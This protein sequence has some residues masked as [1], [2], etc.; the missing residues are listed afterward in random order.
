NA[1]QATRKGKLQRALNTLYGSVLS[2]ISLTVPAV[3]LI[4]EV[5]G[6]KVI[7]GLEQY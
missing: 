5:T 7:L 4:G 3:L 2:T 6:T 1:I